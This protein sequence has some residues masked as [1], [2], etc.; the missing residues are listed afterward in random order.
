M[1]KFLLL[2]IFFLL[3]NFTLRAQSIPPISE[4]RGCATMHH[5]Q[6]LE[7]KYPA[8]KKQRAQFE[9]NLNNQIKFNQFTRQQ[10]SNVVSI[11]VVVHIIH[12]VKDGSIGGTNI[13]EEQILSQI[14]TL[15]DD[16]R[17][18]PGTMGDNT[19]PV[20]VDTKIEFCL[21]VTDPNC[22]P[23]NGITRH[24]SARSDF[25]YNNDNE[26][27]KAFGYWPSDQYLN[28]W[29]CN[30]ANNVLGYAQF[31]NYTNLPGLNQFEL[32]ATTDGVVI[33]STAFGNQTGTANAGLFKY[34]RT[35]T[36]EIGHWLGLKHIWGDNE[37]SPNCDTDYCDDTPP[38]STKSP[39]NASCPTRF[40]TCG[41]Q[42]YQNMT[43]NYMDYSADVCMNIFTHDQQ[44]RMQTT[45]NVSPLRLKLLSAKGCQYNTTSGYPLQVDFDTH[46]SNLWQITGPE[47]QF[48][49]S[50][51]NPG[52]KMSTTSIQCNY[53]QS[54]TIGA[55]SN[56]DSPFINFKESNNPLLIF[57]F[58]YPTTSNG[59]TDT[60]ILYY[61][62]GCNA[63]AFV[64][65]DTLTG[66]SLITSSQL[67]SNPY[68]PSET[69]WKTKKINLPFLKNIEQAKIRF[70]GIS[71]QMATLYLDNINIL[72]YQVGC[73]VGA[74]QIL[75]FDRASLTEN[76]IAFIKVFDLNGKVLAS[77]TVYAD[78]NDIYSYD[79][80]Y[81]A[82]GM[83]I[84]SLQTQNNAFQTKFVIAH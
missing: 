68:L 69:D 45:L 8:F 7:E 55:Y 28:I 78:S 34:G 79:L 70:K 2:P 22:K 19:N 63:D 46:L 77:K 38:Q 74:D 82:A 5:N 35:A 11:P 65:F 56:F 58:S 9:F 3:V 76:E 12:N 21:A 59:L 24:Y 80:S 48:L 18:M 51:A 73:Y 4:D 53:K 14:K 23:T 47:S 26:V 81:L 32:G 33:K 29:V 72:S 25:D 42:V 83:Y 20:G 66:A 60:L 40:S 16:Y 31:P 6:F 44:T 61:A 71:Q 10:S 1:T 57:D 15:N 13:S 30:L 52:A 49:W 39:S 84:A 41:S 36:H 50:T 75:H 17:K 67:A 62:Q 54:N 37:N 27:I 43:E 64:P